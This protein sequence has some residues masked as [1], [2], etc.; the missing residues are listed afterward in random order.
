MGYEYV[1]YGTTFR[2]YPQGVSKKQISKWVKGMAVMLYVL[3][4]SHGAVEIVPSSLGVSIGKTSVHRGVQAAAG[5]VPGM[6]R[7]Q[8]LEGYQIRAVGADVTSVRCHRKWIP[9]GIS[10][11]HAIVWRSALLG[12]RNAGNADRNER[13]RRALSLAQPLF[14]N[15]RRQIHGPRRANQT[16]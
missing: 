15:P 2:V 12:L 9:L 6:K 14:R 8:F 7:E 3:G 1:K 16:T 4:L 11:D 13:G 5:K 10:N